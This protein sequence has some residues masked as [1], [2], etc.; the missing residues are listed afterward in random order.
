MRAKVCSLVEKN[1]WRTLD[2]TFLQKHPFV[3]LPGSRIWIFCPDERS[4]ER[5]SQQTCWVPFEILNE[6]IDPQ[7][8]FLHMTS[9][10]FQIYMRWATVKQTST[11]LCN[12]INVTN[13]DGFKP[14]FQEYKDKKAWHAFKNIQ[15]T[16]CGT[17]ELLPWNPTAS[18]GY[19]GNGGK[20]ACIYLTSF[21]G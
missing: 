3:R 6:P 16:V 7:D 1:C 15:G 21:E 20:C 17:W 19:L 5:N 9:L 4:T 11:Q 13:K 10:L 18:Y 12:V 8:A 14:L 2:A